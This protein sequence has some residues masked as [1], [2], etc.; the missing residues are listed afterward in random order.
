[1]DGGI[2]SGARSL[3]LGELSALVARAASGLAA[4]GIGENDAVALALRNDFAFFEATF[5][6]TMLGAYAVPVNWHFTAEEVGYIA[7]DC[8]ARVVVVHADLL[9]RIAEGLPENA[10]VLVVPTPPEI[11][12]A[13]NVP[14]EA[15]EVHEPLV[16]WTEWLARQSSWTDPPRPSRN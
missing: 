2:L 1:M 6:A 11:G 13:Y 3:A 8:A 15:C 5:G 16:D 9:P 10:Q 12:A 4:L 7:R 14:A